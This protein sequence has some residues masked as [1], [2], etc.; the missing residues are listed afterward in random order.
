MAAQPIDYEALAKQHGA[1]SS[2]KP[3]ID[4]AAIAKQHGAVSS[5]VAQPI[6]SGAQMADAAR[7]SLPGVVNRVNPEGTLATPKQINA[8]IADAVPMIAGT[9][10]SFIPGVGQL[11]LGARLGVQFLAGAGGEAAKQ[12][13]KDKFMGDKSGPQTTA[14]SLK[15][16]A[17]GG[18][19]SAAMELPFAAASKVIGGI[20]RP[21]KENLQS[22]LI[23]G[24]KL[25]ATAPISSQDVA[26]ANNLYELGLTAGE[27]N[28]S[29]SGRVP[30][31][32]QWVGDKSPLGKI[33]AKDAQA[34]GA[35]NAAN[36][37]ENSA[38]KLSSVPSGPMVTGKAVQKGISD[39]KG[40]FSGEAAKRYAEV[41]RLAGNAGTVDLLPTKAEMAGIYD[42]EMRPIADQGM[43]LGD[44]KKL[45]EFMEPGKPT[46]VSFSEADKLRKY[47][48][49]VGA[50]LTSLNKNQAQGI[51]ARMAA[52]ID[53][54]MEKGAATSGNPQVYQKYKDARDFYRQGM[55]TFAHPNI[56]VAAGHTI[57]EQ[58][59]DLIS[60]KAE[61]TAI[62]ARKAI[63]DI[64]MA[65]GTPEQKL[66]AQQNWDN[67]R[68]EWLHHNIIGDPN[69]SG[70]D[71]ET[72]MGMKK[73]M[74]KWGPDVLKQMFSDTTGKE[75][76]TNL[77]TVA[78]AMSRIQTPKAGALGYHAVTK[79]PGMIIGGMAGSAGGGIG[80]TL[81]AAAG[82]L[83]TAV[84]IP[85]FMSWVI[86]NK[87]ATK[88]LTEGLGAKVSAAN[89]GANAIAKLTK[90]YF[91]S[92][93][94][95]EEPQ[96]LPAVKGVKR[97]N[98][99][100]GTAAGD[101]K[102]SSAAPPVPPARPAAK[103]VANPYEE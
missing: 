28:P 93:Q 62:H 65:H 60:P 49:N 2:E 59:L 12:F 35:R 4:Y 45:F 81:G 9:A 73:N 44:T 101:V 31:L 3:V 26:K 82:T 16:I 21:G 8:Q 67:F 51:S 97:E 48:S 100:A 95:I 87:S 1:V 91:D 19:S 89:T 20:S 52:S 11:G 75:V 70:A 38:S 24:Q 74:E 90:A 23:T 39:S 94:G 42:K 103:K 47:F 53:A 18:L 46:T 30:K 86:H 72:L 66:A 63:L 40:I 77:K 55:E 79:L 37:A 69:R 85:G 84:A 27:V 13:V 43:P 50:D 54:A 32:V 68:E 22:T 58:A 76:I 92:Q 98:P 56:E 99:L 83:A 80:E 41:D 57:P 36:W 29:G 15:D 96:G 61:S 5:D 17:T 7:H 34:Q 78:E 88:M 64:P 33:Y 102:V 71:L 25:P 10:A 6:T 14:D